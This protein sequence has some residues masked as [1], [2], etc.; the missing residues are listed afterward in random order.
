LEKPL[1]YQRIG[2]FGIMD[3]TTSRAIH[4]PIGSAKKKNIAIFAGNKI[5]AVH[6]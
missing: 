6:T 4:I 1:S 3:A 5:K 2:K